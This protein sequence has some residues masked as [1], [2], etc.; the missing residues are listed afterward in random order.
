MKKTPPHQRGHQDPEGEVGDA[1]RVL[2]LS[3]AL[4]LG[5][6]DAD[7]EG[8]G[9][10]E[11][12]AVKGEGDLSVE[13]SPAP[14]EED[15]RREDADGDLVV[16]ERPA[17]GDALPLPRQPP[18]KGH[19]APQDEEGGRGDGRGEA[20][21]VGDGEADEDGEHLEPVGNAEPPGPIPAR[22]G[23]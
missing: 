22:G 23:A 13:H 12:V 7:D 6:P 5:Q 20:Q 8:R 4:A 2:P 3:P 14:Q 21:A 15:Q 9:D 18:A 17:E 16:G 11:A 10:E 19:R 1:L